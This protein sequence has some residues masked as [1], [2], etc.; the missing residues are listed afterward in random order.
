VATTS[1]RIVAVALF[2]LGLSGV[3]TA[4]LYTMK[5]FTYRLS[6]RLPST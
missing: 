4:V 5:R 3:V 6:L 1:I 2:F